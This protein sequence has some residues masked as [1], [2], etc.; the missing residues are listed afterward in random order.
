MSV[1]L[2]LSCRNPS[3]KAEV[4]QEALQAGTDSQPG[5]KEDNPNTN[6][7]KPAKSVGWE[8][9]Y[10]FIIDGCLVD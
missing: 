9:L 4:G 2:Y 8:I 10:I 7:G 3:L 1:I 6:D 5:K